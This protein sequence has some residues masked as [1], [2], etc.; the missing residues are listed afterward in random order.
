MATLRTELQA[1]KER[2]S[3]AGA[4]LAALETPSEQTA[5][6]VAAAQAAA[7]GAS[8]MDA[9]AQSALAAE[10]E[11]TRRAC[12]ALRSQADGEKKKAEEAQADV[13]KLVRFDRVVP[14]ENVK[15]VFVWF[16]VYTCI[17]TNTTRGYHSLHLAV[18]STPLL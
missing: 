4:A 12:D 9:A 2:E 17:R 11:S 16:A 1:A 5:A 15:E 7:A 8:V 13:K 18:E 6:A 3:A 10:L 14:L